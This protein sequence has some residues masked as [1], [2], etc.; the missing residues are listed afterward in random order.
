MDRPEPRSPRGGPPRPPPRPSGGRMPR[1]CSNRFLRSSSHLPY[2]SGLKIFFMAAANFSCSAFSASMNFSRSARVTVNCLTSVSRACWACLSVRAYWPR[3]RSTTL[4][5]SGPG[6]P[7]GSS[8]TRVTRRFLSAKM[9]PPVPMPMPEARIIP[10]TTTCISS[11]RRLRG[12]RRGGRG[13]SGFGSPTITVSP[14][15]ARPVP[16]RG[17]SYSSRTARPEPW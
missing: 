4:F 14:A 1:K 17:W 13:C 7:G 9:V 12:G 11:W 6:G 15:A 8:R 2:C 10:A 16:S 5:G 3:H